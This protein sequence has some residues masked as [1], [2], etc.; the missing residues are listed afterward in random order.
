GLELKANDKGFED[1]PAL[2]ALRDESKKQANFARAQ[3]MPSN[4]TLRIGSGT[5]DEEKKNQMD[6]VDE[7]DED[8]KLARLLQEEE[9]WKSRKQRK[10][11]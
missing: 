6:S 5:G 4:V 8:A 2:I 7:E 3:V 10:N 1:I 11:P 9:D